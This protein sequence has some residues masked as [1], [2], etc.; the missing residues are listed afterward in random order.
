MGFGE[1]KKIVVG[2]PFVQTKVGE[3]S[4]NLCFHVVSEKVQPIL[5]YPRLKALQLIVDCEEDKLTN[6]DRRMI[7]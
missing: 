3:W 2:Q 5:G 4:H 6:I 7:L 1:E